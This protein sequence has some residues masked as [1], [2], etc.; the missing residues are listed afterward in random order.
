MAVVGSGISGVEDSFCSPPTPAAKA[1]VRE[2]E[3]R[4]SCKFFGL[5]EANLTKR[6]RGLSSLSHCLTSA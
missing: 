2:E 1:R 3:Q 5:P 4:A 6:I